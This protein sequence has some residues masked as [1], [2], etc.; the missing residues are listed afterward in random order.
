T[1]NVDLNFK[2]F[3]EDEKS[4]LVFGNSEL[5]YSA[6]KNVVENG[7]KYSPNHISNVELR[8]PDSR[9]E[10]TVTNEGDIIAEEEIENIFQPFY[11]SGNIGQA[12]GF[13]LG[14]ALAKRIISLHKGQI[15]VRS[16]LITGTVFTI[17][18]PSMGVVPSVLR[19]A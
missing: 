15:E 5:L 18:L 14:L 13:G 4:F 17:T 8:F 12:K 2:E 19:E 11:R 7:C 1:Y 3:P 16:D 6:I 9:I 10:I